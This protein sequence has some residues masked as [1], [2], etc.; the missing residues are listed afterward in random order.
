MHA[1]HLD[2]IA[3]EEDL[4]TVLAGTSASA[5]IVQAL[6][7]CALCGSV[8]HEAGGISAMKMNAM[9]SR[10]ECIYAPHST[11][12]VPNWQKMLEPPMSLLHSL[13]AS[14]K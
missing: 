5:G 4:P 9:K 12:H 1:S 3:L 2:L 11:T 14:H 8:Q 10:F 13:F 7:R 6:E